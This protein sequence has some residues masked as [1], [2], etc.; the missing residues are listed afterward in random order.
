MA[1]IVFSFVACS[2]D[3]FEEEKE[4]D[5]AI[6]NK[7]QNNDSTNN[8]QNVDSTNLINETDTD[9]YVNKEVIEDDSLGPADSAVWISFKDSFQLGA[10][11][12]SAYWSSF[13]RGIN[14]V[15]VDEWVPAG[16][17]LGQG[18]DVYGDYLFGFA[19]G[20]HDMKVSNLAAREYLGVCSTE[21]DYIY[22]RHANCQNFTTEYYKPDDL[23]PLLLVSGN[24][25]THEGDFI[26]VSYLVRIRAWGGSFRAE[27]VQ[28]I[29]TIAGTYSDRDGREYPFGRYS[30]IMVDR[31][32]GH[33]YVISGSNIYE[34]ELP[35]LFDEGGNVISESVLTADKVIR[36]LDFAYKKNTPQGAC[37]NNGLA[38]IAGGVY[39]QIVDLKSGRELNSIYL[40]SVGYNYELEDIA[41]WRG[42]MI[43]SG[44]VK[45]G[46]YRVY[47]E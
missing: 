39:L 22:A 45:N 47:W 10:Y 29:S 17:G 8:N 32:S 24:Q 20:M 6:M 38:Y 36:R 16:S 40:P 12:D 28:A 18:F 42:S 9:V 4:Y 34:M 13:K 21:L 35:A 25:S 3:A 44:G 14:H 43:L 7:S 27:Q 1:I 26:G 33:I 31:E 30:N 5:E 11:K 15:T 23:I 46:I 19:V 41:F 37:V 2:K